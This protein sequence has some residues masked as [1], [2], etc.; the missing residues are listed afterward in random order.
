[1]PTDTKEQEQFAG[2]SD[3]LFAKLLEWNEFQDEKKIVDDYIDK[4]YEK[5][6]LL[7]THTAKELLGL[8]RELAMFKFAVDKQLKKENKTQDSSEIEDRYAYI[9]TLRF[10]SQRE[11]EEAIKE[12]QPLFES[13]LKRNDPLF[14]AKLL[15]EENTLVKIVKEKPVAAAGGEA[16]AVFRN[17]KGAVTL[18]LRKKTKPK[19]KSKQGRGAIKVARR[20][21]SNGLKWKCAGNFF[22]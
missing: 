17:Y 11:K 1:M 9:A 19:L 7:R 5:Y 2:A 6:Q 4:V 21:S 16:V 20:L 13:A 14:Y 15:R 10:F 3:V 12:A 22:E 8:D 18:Y